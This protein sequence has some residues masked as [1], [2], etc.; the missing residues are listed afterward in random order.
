MPDVIRRMVIERLAD[1]RGS[2]LEVGCGEG[3]TLEGL[4]AVNRDARLCGIDSWPEI[5]S[6]ASERRKS[7]DDWELVHGDG[8]HLPFDS[9][10]FD[11][12]IAINLILNLHGSEEVGELLSEV[13]R[14]VK[15][16][17]TALYD[18]RNAWNPLVRLA[19]ATVHL[20]DPTI[21]VPLRTD[22]IS[23]INRQTT[24]AGLEIIERLPIGAPAFC[25]PGWLVVAR[26][27]R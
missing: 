22:G 26:R 1:A 17:C 15:P 3:L 5:L 27:R 18:F 25:P 14:V 23:R 24:E 4:R 16:G 19:Y 21:K 6:Q 8:L 2:I 7:E 9:Q 11:A 10:T 13:A 12:V 20:H